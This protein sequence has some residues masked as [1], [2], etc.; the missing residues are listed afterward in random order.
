MFDSLSERLEGVVK[1]LRGLHKLTEENIKEPLREVRLALL[2]ADVNL[3]VVK[4]FIA[5]V[6][7]EALGVETLEGLNPGQT[8]IKIV[9]DRLTLLLG[10]EKADITFAER[11]PTVILMTG[12]QGSG[13]TTTTA[14]L[15]KAISKQG[16]NPML[17]SVDVHRPAAMEQL[18]ILAS[19]LEFPCH[20]TSPDMAPVAICKDALKSLSKHNANVLLV[21]TAGRLHIDG[22]MMEELEAI[23]KTVKPTEIFFIADSMTGQD[24]VNVAKAFN[25]KIGMTG[26]I[27]TKFDGDSRGGAALSIKKVTG[28]PIKFLGVGEKVDQ[29]ETFHPDRLAGR[30]LGMGDMMS[31]I[32]KT[33]ETV[34]Q[35][36]AEAQAKKMLSA[37]FDLNDFLDQIQMIK[38]MGPLDQIMKMIPG[39]GNALKD[40]KT[41]PYELIMTE[42][43]INSMTLKERAAPGIINSSRKRRIAKGCGLELFDINKLLR[44]FQKMKKMMKKMGKSKGKK[45]MMDQFAGLGLDQ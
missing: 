24:A 26:V 1:R 21:D 45:S 28:V 25:E 36:K 37:T 14:K 22:E 32:E 42:A 15:A 33:Q 2:E 7:E 44:N 16:Y 30:I 18:K 19:E 41:D 23:K 39:M 31:L 35:K 40:V 11:G 4:E 13:K 20:D 9:N 43:I 8:M 17:V 10:G 5:E 6:R 3:A 34:D 27:L 29:L 12:L 38:N